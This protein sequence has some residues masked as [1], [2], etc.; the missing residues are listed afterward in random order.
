M[1]VGPSKDGLRF[2]ALSLI[3]V[4]DIDILRADLNEEGYDLKG[5][6]LTYKIALHFY[7][8]GKTSD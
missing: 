5:S 8:T 1:P 4:L 7:R 2:A 3:H 6:F